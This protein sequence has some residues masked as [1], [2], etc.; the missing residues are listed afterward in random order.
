MVAKAKKK[1]RPAG[2]PKSGIDMEKIQT[3]ITA[4]AYADLRDIAERNHW[5]LNTAVVLAIEHFIAMKRTEEAN[6]N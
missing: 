1:H 3:R 5:S 2:R 6:R 4:D